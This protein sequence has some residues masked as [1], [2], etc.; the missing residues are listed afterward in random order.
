MVFLVCVDVDLLGGNISAIK[1]ITEICLQA[2]RET[3]VGVNIDIQN[4]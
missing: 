3:G 4:I 2:G 1:N